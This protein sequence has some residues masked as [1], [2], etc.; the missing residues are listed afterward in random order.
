[1]AFFVPP[2]HVAVSTLS[3]ASGGVTRGSV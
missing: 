3:G 1:V 2:P